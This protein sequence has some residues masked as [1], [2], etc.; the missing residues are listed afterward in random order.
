MESTPYTGSTRWPDL[1]VNK[2]EMTDPLRWLI[3][4]WWDMRNAGK[5]SLKY[6]LGVV[7]ISG[8]LTLALFITDSMFLLP[9]LVSGFF[10]VAPSWGSATIN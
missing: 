2:I 4:G 8:I 3:L 7:I 6:G 10:L 5:Y 1:V 9:F